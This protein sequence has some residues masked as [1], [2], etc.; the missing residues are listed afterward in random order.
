MVCDVANLEES[1][2]LLKPGIEHGMEQGIEHGTKQIMEW[3]RI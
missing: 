1:W 3:N 2:S